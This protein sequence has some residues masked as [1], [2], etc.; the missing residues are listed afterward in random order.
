MRVRVCARA[1]VRVRARGFSCGFLCAC[2]RVFLCA[3]ATACFDASSRSVSVVAAQEAIA[4]SDST[5]KALAGFGA[6]QDS[7]NHPWAG[8]AG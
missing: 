1:R 2:V 3:F 6:K 8:N 5:A 7:L 4:P